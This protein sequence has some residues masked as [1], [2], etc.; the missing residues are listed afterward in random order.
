MEDLQGVMECWSFGILECWINGELELRSV[1]RR[2]PRLGE[3]GGG[4]LCV[5][6]SLREMI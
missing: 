3:A 1:L 6:K 4:P 2:P 5:A